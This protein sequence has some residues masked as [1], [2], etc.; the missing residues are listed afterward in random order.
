MMMRVLLFLASSARALQP[1]KPVSFGY[2]QLGAA[3]DAFELAA[4]EA[5]KDELRV[6]YGSEGI[7]RSTAAQAADAL[8]AAQTLDAIEAALPLADAA[9]L[10][11]D[12]PEVV[13]A[14]ARRD[15]ARAAEER[16]A[17]LEEIARAA[18]CR[19]ESCDVELLAG[20]LDEARSL[21]VDASS[22]VEKS[23]ELVAVQG[24][25]AANV[26][27]ALIFSDE[28]HA[29]Y[30]PLAPPPRKQAAVEDVSVLGEEMI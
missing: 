10:P 9:G 22:I 15:R 17:V 23:R 14:L 5:L 7:E 29:I 16:T 21:G 6:K 24:N 3:P 19:V 12:A 25:R 30:D 2:V 8:D 28:A 26:A 20:L 1:M 11:A 18:D 13:A 27:A 4:A